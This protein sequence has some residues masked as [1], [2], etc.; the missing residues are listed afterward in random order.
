MRKQLTSYTWKKDIQT[1]ESVKVDLKVGCTFESLGDSKVECPIYTPKQNVWGRNQVSEFSKTLSGSNVQPR[2]G[3]SEQHPGNTLIQPPPWPKQL[4]PNTCIIHGASD[5]FFLSYNKLLFSFLG[6]LHA[7]SPMRKCF[8][9]KTFLHWVITVVFRDLDVNFCERFL[10]TRIT[11]ISC[12]KLPVNNLFSSSLSL[13]IYS[14]KYDLWLKFFLSLALRTITVD[15][16]EVSF[17]L[18]LP[19][20][21]SY[22][23][24]NRCLIKTSDVKM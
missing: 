16:M 14:Y 8:P 3:F 6:A 11:N 19:I 24:H 7:L 21:K 12:S 10:Q 23:V 22:L 9:L 15:S 4:S 2:S 5:R 17:I 13:I 18:I 1:S 20:S